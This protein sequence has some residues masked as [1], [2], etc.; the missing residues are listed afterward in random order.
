M[1]GNYGD[2]KE[3]TRDVKEIMAMWRMETMG[4]MLM[5]WWWMGK[6]LGMI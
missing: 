1:L 5:K 4:G 6:W 2:V 3:I